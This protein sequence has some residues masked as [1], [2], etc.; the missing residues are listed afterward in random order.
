MDQFLLALCGLPASGKT[1]LAEAIQDALKFDVEIVSSDE[2]RDAEYYTD[3]KPEKE[4][5]VRQASL[6]RTAEFIKQGKNVIHDD[7][8]YYKSMRHDLFKIALQ[9]R[10]SFAIVHVSTS[11]E[12]AI[13]WNKMREHSNITENIIRRISE[14][15][16]TPGGRYLWD[17]PDVEV[18]MASQSLDSVLVDIIGMLETLE[19]VEEPRPIRVSE[20]TGEII[21]QI[22]R[23][24][25]NEFL[26]EHPELRGNREVSKV[27]RNV[28]KNAIENNTDTKMIRETLL[29]HLHGLIE[30]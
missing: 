4:R 15:F 30:R 10:C 19:V 11:L 14:R 13:T 25:V 16:D 2:W 27:R 24:T 1:T 6:T 12:N 17:Y 21:D 5:R 22:T 28:L 18:D 7:T 29:K 20:S 9:R 8:N 23:E 26:K 3:W